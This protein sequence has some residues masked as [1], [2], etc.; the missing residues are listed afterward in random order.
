[1]IGPR[2]PNAPLILRT[3]DITSTSVNISWIV[4]SVTYTPENYTV[5]Y[6]TS[7]NKLSNIS[8]I[9][10]GTTD[11]N[12][13]IELRNKTYSIV[14]TDLYPGVKYDYYISTNNTRGTVNSSDNSFYTNETGMLLMKILIISYPFHSTIRGAT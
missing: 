12:E 10:R 6:K 3:S 7:L 1:M 5:H 9:V 2:L 4:T 11:I 14:L 8:D 13:F